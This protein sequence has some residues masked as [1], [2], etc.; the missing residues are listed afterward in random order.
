MNSSFRT[1][2]PLSTLTRREALKLAGA[3]LT[4]GLL[5]PGALAASRRTKKVVIAGGGIAG[6]CCAFELMQHG[7]DVTVLEA[8]DHTGG[9]VLSTHEP[10]SDGLYAD[11]GAEQCT[12][13][14]Y[15]IYR[16]YVHQLGLPLIPY[17]RRD[18]ILR[19][20]DGKPYT[21]EMLADRAVLAGFG[22]NWV[23]QN[24]TYSIQ[25]RVVFQCRRRFWKEDGIG[26][27]IDI[28]GPALSGVWE[29]ADEVPGERGLLMSSAM[30]AITQEQALAALKGA[31]PGKL[32]DI[33]KVYIKE[34]YRD[35]WS[36]RCERT[37]C[38]VGDLARLWPNILQPHGRIH[39]AGA[40]ADNGRSGMEAATRSAHRVAREIDVA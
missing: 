33:E 23:M 10:F 13:P 19:Y 5:A 28:G 31:Y 7:H 34:W 1:S 11:L 29:M 24:V 26:P 25:S 39:F 36:A 21:E 37:I 4:S 30:P 20:I 40:Y 6:L 12:E 18:N 16:G 35:P 27:N 8:S 9:H 14:G 32:G 17:R 22:F 3:A 15:E 2:R 38:K